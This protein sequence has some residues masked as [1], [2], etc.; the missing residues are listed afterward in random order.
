LE[1]LKKIDTDWTNA[2]VSASKTELE[3]YIKMHP[4]SIHCIEARIMI[5]SLDWLTAL[6]TDTS[7][8]YCV[9]M[10]A[11]AD[12][13]H[14]DEAH[15]R[16]DRLEAQKVNA[17][18]KRMISELFLNY[19]TALSTQN[20]E[21]L[22]STLAP[23]LTSF[24]H[25]DQA[26]K[27]DVVTYMN[28]IYEPDVQRISFSPNNDWKIE[29]QPVDDGTFSYLVD[30]SVDQRFERSDESKERF[31]TYK[32]V[33]RITPDCKIGELNMKKVIQ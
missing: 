30:F 28:R 14:Y 22:T 5:D 9:Y 18:D 19:Y 17:N 23:V 3:K 11:H 8:G 32:V 10:S 21:L 1:A 31:C 24:L 6:A 25:K 26:T 20:E 29:K 16:H 7:E 27:S 13:A 4:E 15:D 2:A 12:G 33:A